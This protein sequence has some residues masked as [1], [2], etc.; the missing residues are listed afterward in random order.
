VL[1]LAAT[2]LADDDRTPEAL[3]GMNR[4]RS[5]EEFL[6]AVEDWA[7][8]QQ[9]MVFADMDGH[10]GMIAPARVPVRK[11]GEGWLPSPGWDGETDWT[12]FIPFA[13]LPYEE[14][15]RLVTANN[16]IVPDDYPWFISRDWDLPYRAERITALLDA[17]EGLLDDATGVVRRIDDTREAADAAILRVEEAAGRANLAL[18]RIDASTTSADALLL[19]A[20]EAQARLVE[21]MDALEPSLRTLQPTLERLAETTDPK[22]V[23]ALVSLVDRLPALAEQ[24]ERDV[25]PVMRTLESVAP[26]LHELLHVSRELN[27][28][29]TKLPGMGRIRKRADDELREG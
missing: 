29:L 8:P 19:A 10:T 25:V 26:D 14:G 16:K 1:A 13:Q 9:S 15:P 17:A 23:D 5:A 4:A 2:F 24:V 6:R 3:Y 21:L 27:E 7:A 22:E 20:T 28:M 12:G 11:N 18:D